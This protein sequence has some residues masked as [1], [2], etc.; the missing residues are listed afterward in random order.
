MESTEEPIEGNVLV[1]AQTW[2]VS[3]EDDGKRLDLFLFEKRVGVSRSIVQK[4]IAARLVAVD[5]RAIRSSFRLKFG[6]TITVQSFEPPREEIIGEDIPLSVLFEDDEIVAIDKPAGMVVHPAKG[7]WSGTLTAALAFRF[8]ELS[9]A[10]GTNR[11][12][13]IHRLDRD[14]S[15]VILVAKTDRA[16]IQLAKQFEKRTVRKRYTAIVTPAPDRDADLIEL[17]IGVHP[18]QREKMMI[19]SDHP[20]S[21]P[22]STYY[23]VRWRHRGF[24]LLDVFPR[25][26]RTHQIRVHLA[27]GGSPILC[28]RLYSG[29]ARI[30]R[31]TLL[32]S[33]DDEVILGRQALHAAAIEFK[34]PITHLPLTL[35]SPLATDLQRF[36]DLLEKDRL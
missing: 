20:T 35:E 4:L 28:D 11:P 18:Y 3:A 7:H 23:E 29:R 19:R 16:H 17:P 33:N 24:A 25:T 9:S 14:T 27:H 21:R 34:H 26:G 6:Q 10:G 13:I 36:L 1:P 15:G 22:A 2:P 12:G 5:G 8:K 32:Q 31:G 30:T